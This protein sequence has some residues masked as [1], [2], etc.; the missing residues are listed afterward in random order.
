MSRPPSN[1]INSGNKPAKPFGQRNNGPSIVG[2]QSP[3]SS[4]SDKPSNQSDSASNNS[5]TA[6]V[7]IRSQPWKPPIANKKR[8][9]S[10]GKAPSR[11]SSFDAAQ[12]S[13]SSNA[14]TTAEPKK[15]NMLRS[16]SQPAK[17]LSAAETSPSTDTT[18]T[19]AQKPNII[20]SSPQVEK[21]PDNTSPTSSTATPAKKPNI[22]RSSSRFGIKQSKNK[23]PE[24]QTQPEP[25]SS[26]PSVNSKSNESELS[27][28]AETPT[29]SIPET[30]T[31]PIAK[32]LKTSISY[33][34][35]SSIA[36]QSQA[37][38]EGITTSTSLD[39][40][41][42]IAT[43]AEIQHL[44]DMPS[45]VAAEMAKLDKPSSLPKRK[46]LWVHEVMN[47]SSQLDNTR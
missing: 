16:L 43:K 12:P 14:T 11:P 19:V 10:S 42:Q 5:T 35:I 32:P 33:H 44:D 1:F 39:G 8:I 28:V 41:S 24:T 21:A 29:T 36:E 9:I 23:L 13:P 40:I 38:P 37:P 34:E 15:P 26:I 27:S 25:P 17:S 3:T 31:T 2:I 4:S 46:K 20:R 7:I 30:P 47:Y 18:P 22:I 6:P 45:D